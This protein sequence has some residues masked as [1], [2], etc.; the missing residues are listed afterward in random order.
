ML[1]VSRESLRHVHGTHL[2]I[3]KALWPEKRSLQVILAVRPREA[4]RRQ[5]QDKRISYAVGMDAAQTIHCFFK[6]SS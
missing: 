5:S 2:R 6:Y 3:E 1:E 4:L